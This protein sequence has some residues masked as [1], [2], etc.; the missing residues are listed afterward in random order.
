M[1]GV[2]G[3]VRLFLHNIESETL[4]EPRRVVL[5][6]HDGARFETT[7]EARSGAGKRVLG[8]I[9]GLQDRELAASLKDWRIAIRRA[10]LPDPKDEFYVADILGW[11][12]F[13]GDRQVGEVLA[14]HE[15][16]GDDILEIATAADPL[17]VPMIERFVLDVD[18]DHKR[19]L[20]ADDALDD[21]AVDDEAPEGP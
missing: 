6:R 3:E 4:D 9:T 7:L 15:T 10:D 12:V 2:T 17:F 20:V 19:V 8:R 18:F 14:V 5:I 1:F 21:D 16:D 13:Q 11:P